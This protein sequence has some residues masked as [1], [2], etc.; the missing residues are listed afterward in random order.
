VTRRKFLRGALIVT[1]VATV[2][3]VAGC[4]G[5]SDGPIVTVCG[6]NIGRAADLVGSGPFYVDASVSAPPAPVVAAAGSS[7]MNVRVSPNCSTGA[8]VSVSDGAVIEVQSEI[9]ATDRADE[10]ISVSPLAV[11]RSTVT[12]RRGHASPTKVTFVVKPGVVPPQ[13]NQRTPKEP[14]GTT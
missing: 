14:S 7:P 5:P 10:V 3:G 12:I 8:Q 13:T 6:A 1:T 4:G 9:Q 11:G 2:A